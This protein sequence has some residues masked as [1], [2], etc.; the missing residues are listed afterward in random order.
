[1]R[2]RM[3]VKGKS[4]WWKAGG[5]RGAQ[6]VL[7]RGEDNEEAGADGPASAP[8]DRE[9]EMVTGEVTLGPQEDLVF[10]GER[11]RGEMELSRGLEVEP[12]ECDVVLDC[13][14]VE[15]LV[16]QQ[17]ARESG[18]AAREQATGVP[19]EQR[20]RKAREP[21]LE[22]GPQTRGKRQRDCY[23]AEMVL[24]SKVARTGLGRACAEGILKRST[25]LAQTKQRKPAS[26]EGVLPLNVVKIRPPK[27]VVALACQEA[28]RSSAR[29][30]HRQRQR[31]SPAVVELCDLTGDEAGHVADP[32]EKP[33]V[34]PASICYPAGEGGFELHEAELLALAPLTD[35]NGSLINFYIRHLQQHGAVRP[36]FFVADTYFYAKLCQVAARPSPAGAAHDLRSLLAYL[37]CPDLFA[38]NAIAIPVHATGHW[39]LAVV[40]A[41]G[42]LAPLQPGKKRAAQGPAPFILHLDSLPKGRGG[43]DTAL[44]A[45]RLSR[46]VKDAWRAREAARL[47]AAGRAVPKAWHLPDLK[48]RRVQVPQQDN[49]CDCGLFLLL[50]LARF[51]AA[52]PD[53]I[54]CAQ[55]DHVFRGHDYPLTDAGLLRARLLQ[56]A[57]RVFRQQ[58]GPHWR[59]TVSA[60]TGAA[61][62][63]Q[64]EADPRDEVEEEHSAC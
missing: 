42:L 55:V 36:G 15:E 53:V 16:T 45:R 14:V 62:G 59:P 19:A 61:L 27:K 30:H 3:V 11:K 47:V 60:A 24:R 48:E 40:C 5:E 57:W 38:H 63:V 64:L 34:S 26:P 6:V 18:V 49:S 7:E 13:E 29:G 9:A 32:E 58:H 8:S 17:E 35:L 43:H 23:P 41:P 28:R 37:A 21:G 25:R 46:F 50:N 44:V 22:E 54:H 56:L 20:T 51:L 52:A 1:M 39:S 2:L 12:L 4:E 33:A 10:V 31:S